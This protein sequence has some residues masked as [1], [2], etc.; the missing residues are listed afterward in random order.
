MIPS[1]REKR[2]I[3]LMKWFLQVFDGHKAPYPQHCFRGIAYYMRAHIMRMNKKAV[4]WITDHKEME[5]QYRA[6]CQKGRR[7]SSRSSTASTVRKGAR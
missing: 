7:C 2:A 4:M 6:F 5:K 3:W 1:D